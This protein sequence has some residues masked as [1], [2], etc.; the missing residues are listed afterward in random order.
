M[1]AEFLAVGLPGSIVAVVGHRS[2]LTSFFPTA[3][4]L[5]SASGR[6]NVDALRGPWRLPASVDHSSSVVRGPLCL[7]LEK[8]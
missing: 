3:T 6:R 2:L 1:E 5:D 7:V 4:Q 8:F